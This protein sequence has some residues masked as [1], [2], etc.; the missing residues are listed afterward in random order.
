LVVWERGVGVTEA[1]G[2]GACA[3]AAAAQAWGLAG[4]RTAVHMPGGSVDVELGESVI[5]T[6]PAV[7]VADVE[8]PWR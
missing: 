3:V 5:L 2:T 8:V 4:A 1:C 7:H 6:G